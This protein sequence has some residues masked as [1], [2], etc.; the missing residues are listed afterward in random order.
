MEP[1]PTK[2]VKEEGEAHDA[3]EP[4][5]LRGLEQIS[6]LNRLLL[7]YLNPL[8]DLGAHRTLEIDDLG[9]CAPHMCSEV[10][11]DKFEAEWRKECTK[12]LERRSLWWTL[13][14]TVGYGRLALS[15]SLYALY[16]G[17]A[18]IPIIL[19][20]VLVQHFSGIQKVTQLEVWLCVAAMF[21]AP[22]I[23]S[24]FA[25]QSN[26]IVAN[27]SVQFRN[28][29]INKIYRKSLVLSPN[30][31][32]KSSTGQI[33]N[34]FS[35]DTQLIQQC[36]NM[37]NNTVMSPFQIIVCL[38][39]IY[40]EV[41]VSTFVGLGVLIL[42]I[43]LNAQI[44]MAI[45]RFR[46]RKTKITD[47]RVKLMNEILAGI[48]II[49][50]Y[51]WESA[52]EGKVF[53]IRLEELKVLRLMAYTLGIGFSFILA[54]AP[55]ALP[56]LI[57]YSYTRMGNELDA[58]T[59]F[60]TISLFNI[61]QFPFVLLPMGISQFT[62][63][64]VSVKRMFDF[65]LLE[66][67][68]EYV[69]KKSDG[70]VVISMENASL[71]WTSERDEEQIIQSRSCYDVILCKSSSSSSSSSSLEQKST[72]VP[73]GELELLAQNSEEQQQ[74][75]IGINRSIHTII[76]ANFKVKKGELVAIVGSVGSGKS[77]VLSALLGE[78]TRTQGS[79]RLSGT[80]AYCDQKP[81]IIN[82]TLKENILFGYA[83]DE[84]MF[85][86]A[87]EASALKSDLEILPDG[88]MT[89]IGEKGINL[90]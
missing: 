74:G 54:A 33:V 28:C 64:S 51:A 45:H 66:E 47:A 5:N 87:I 13:W 16:A 30:S 67:L 53:G 14:R 48:R 15:M 76:D 90:R 2:D 38:I 68:E 37:L 52:F 20:K 55:V 4:F 60:T 7:R 63:A 73:G 18:Y 82:T 34:M 77:S 29:L 56:V 35:T 81:W 69:N 70:D 78:M 10:L 1:I 41:G 43:P 9:E 17:L 19:L 61:M 58:A 25:A 72:P 62:Q 31:R 50:F 23:A 75:G 46:T 57:F 21:V 44:F 88:I 24:V 3:S 22:T 71:S 36:L 26:V 49:K 39:L 79:I 32:Q 59:A 42:M 84:A 65:F 89:E 40:Q 12:P 85:N 27:M 8:I 11:K 83:Y 6:P 80:T 86:L